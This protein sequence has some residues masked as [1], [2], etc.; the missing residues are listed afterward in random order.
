M[1]IDQTVQLAV[2][3]LTTATAGLWRPPRDAEA[4]VFC[5]KCIHHASSILH[6]AIE[7][8]KTAPVLLQHDASRVRATS[9]L[10]WGCKL[11]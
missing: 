1:Q 3:I 9:S 11:A 2:A 6:L 8:P 7:V 4:A 10:Q 5:Q